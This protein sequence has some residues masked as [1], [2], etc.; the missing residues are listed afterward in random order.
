MTDN[1]K[2]VYRLQMGGLRLCNALRKIAELDG[3]GPLAAIA[4]KALKHKEPD[5]N[6]EKIEEAYQNAISA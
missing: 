6:W 4:N 3:D 5:P 2:N 1:D